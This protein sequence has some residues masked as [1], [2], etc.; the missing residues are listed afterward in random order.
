MLLLIQKSIA[1]VSLLGWRSGDERESKRGGGKAT[2]PTEPPYNQTAQPTRTPI[3]SVHGS[4]AGKE[5]YM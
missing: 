1:N 5:L 2:K 3:R 4:P